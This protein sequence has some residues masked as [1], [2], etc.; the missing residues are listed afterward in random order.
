MPAVVRPRR[1]RRARAVAIRP[2]AI[3]RKR[4]E[5]ISEIGRGGLSLVYKARDLVAARA[6]LADATVAL[7][8][9]VADKS[10]DPDAIAL[11]HREAR[12][13]RDLVHPNIVRVYDMDVEGDVHFMVMELLEGRS[14]ASALKDAPGHRLEPVPVGRLVT[15]VAA[16]LAFAHSRNIV[17]ADL[18]PGNVFIEQSGRVKLIDFNIAYPVARAARSGEEDTVEILG[19]LGAVTPLY[20]SPQRLANA[21]PSVGDD[22]YSLAVLVYIA[23]AGE[24]PFGART[25]REAAEEELEPAPPAGLPRARWLALRRGLALDDA[26]RTADVQRFADEFL[27]PGP[28]ALVR[29]LFRPAR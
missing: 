9:I 14:L 21:E 11:M 8:I 29:G 15:D 18:K 12:R 28:A 20:A 1:A 7:K 22:V 13:L 17:H 2:G 26:Q 10:A 19:R 16:A 25:A 24:R 27:R 3:L 5:L 6:G 4:F 23:L